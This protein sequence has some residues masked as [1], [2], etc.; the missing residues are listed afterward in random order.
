MIAISWKNDFMKKLVLNV[1][2][3]F[4]G[5]TVKMSFVTV[6]VVDFTKKTQIN[7]TQC[8]N[9]TIFLPLFYVKSIIV[10]LV[11]QKIAILR[12]RN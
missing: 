11:L 12:L 9:L 10:N 7:F 8:G 5:K 4:H 3:Q 1:F 6:N 2:K